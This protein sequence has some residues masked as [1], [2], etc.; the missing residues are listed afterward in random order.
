[1]ARRTKI[2]PDA[3]ARL[4]HVFVRDL[5]LKSRIG[6]H[7]HEKRRDQRIRINL[8]LAVSENGTHADDR[9][10]SVVDYED[11]VDRVRRIAASGHVNLVETLAERIAAECLKDRR[12]RG[13]R[14]RVE[15][16]DIL[17]DAASV[18]VEIE[19]RARR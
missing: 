7:R 6:V 9:L 4:R 5:V 3:E 1:V 19:R 17:L 16:P 12:V 14:V 13:V 15:K 18:G 10:D 8:D 2:G 11:I